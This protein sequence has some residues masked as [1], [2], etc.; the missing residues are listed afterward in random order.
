MI[1]LGFS[2]FCMG[3]VLYDCFDF[4]SSF[5]ERCMLLTAD[6]C[7]LSFC[8]VSCWKLVNVGCWSSISSCEKDI[9]VCA[10][11]LLFSF[12]FLCGIPGRLRTIMSSWYWCGLVGLISDILGSGRRGSRGVSGRCDS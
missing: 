11:D 8:S 4:D 5:V 12:S 1:R 7:F 3:I 6:F 10:V 2:S 9:F